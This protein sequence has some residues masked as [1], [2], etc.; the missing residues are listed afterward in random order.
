MALKWSLR[1]QLLYYAVASIISVFL[2][3]IVW[4]AL[5]STE[6]TCFDKK[7]NGG[8]T[9]ADCGGPCAL[10]CQDTARAPVVLWSRAFKVGQRSYTAAAYVQ[11]QNQSAGARAVSYSF[12]LFDDKNLLIVEKTGVIDLPPVRTIAVVEPNIDVGNRVVAR[13][14]F[15]FSTT[16]SWSRVQADAVVPVKVADQLLSRDGSRL[17][18][19]LV[20]DTLEDSPRVMMVGVLFDQYGTARAASKSTINRI[21]RKSSQPIVLTWS[22]GVSDIVRAEITI[23]P[24]F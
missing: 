8:E 11:N 22:G 19:T 7:Q 1:R 24:S 18:A 3:I 17:S 16:A 9:G 20:N 10:L 13:T 2:S 6:A 14:Q 4:Q 21:P 15:S 5:F 12:Q 23:L